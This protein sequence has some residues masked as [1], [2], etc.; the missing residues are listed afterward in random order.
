MEST[1]CVKNWRQT[2][3]LQRRSLCQQLLLLVAHHPKC[4]AKCLIHRHPVH[5][6][7]SGRGGR[8][9]RIKSAQSPASWLNL[10]I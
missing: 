7:H 10:Q 4:N 1:D 5:A 9:G 3:L 6:I 8:G 2:E